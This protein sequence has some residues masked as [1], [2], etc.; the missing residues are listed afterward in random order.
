MSA[1]GLLFAFCGL[2]ATQSTGVELKVLTG[3]P[4]SIL[5]FFKADIHLEGPPEFSLGLSI[6]GAARLHSHSLLKRKGNGT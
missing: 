5:G 3:A 2:G 6:K 1:Q 4:S